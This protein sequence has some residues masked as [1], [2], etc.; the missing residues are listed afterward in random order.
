MLLDAGA[1]VHAAHDAYPAPLELLWL[2]V[3]SRKNI[4]DFFLGQRFSFI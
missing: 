1:G 2:E 4:L 3:F